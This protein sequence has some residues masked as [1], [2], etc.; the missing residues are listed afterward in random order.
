[1]QPLKSDGE[2]RKPLR[3]R[4]IIEAVMLAVYGEI[5]VPSQPVEYVIPYSTIG[6]L[7]EIRDSK[8]PIMPEPDEE[9][10]V[11][12]KIDDLIGLFEQPFFRKKMKRA[13]SVPWTHSLPFPLNDKVSLTILYAL[14]NAEY[15]EEFDPIET[16]L[17]LTCLH[18]KSPL[19]TDQLE[20][21]ERLIEAG[22]PVQVFDV[23]DFEYAVEEVKE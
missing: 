6:E 7:Y 5:L 19:L 23:D 14:E 15:G 8:E 17:I 3:K 1:M 4:F 18:E 20:L 9:K 12:T 2:E 10:H 16:E 13:L 11:R 21:V 22:V